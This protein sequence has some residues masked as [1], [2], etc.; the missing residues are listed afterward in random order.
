MEKE[1]FYMTVVVVLIIAFLALT[2][3]LLVRRSNNGDIE[4]TKRARIRAEACMNIP[5]AAER[6]LCLTTKN[7]GY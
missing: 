7:V 3:S 4:N 1:S 6:T 2:I 5:N